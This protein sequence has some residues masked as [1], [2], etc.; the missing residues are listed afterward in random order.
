[1][2]H[3]CFLENDER[4]YVRT[5]LLWKA[6]VIVPEI[7]R[8]RSRR[9]ELCLARVGEAEATLVGRCGGG[10]VAHLAICERPVVLQVQPL[11]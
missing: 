1:M 4:R 6:G 5:E 11:D 2:K 7:N 10:G 9:K 3:G 8:A